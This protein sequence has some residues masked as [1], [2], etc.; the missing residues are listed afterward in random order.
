MILLDT[1]I[2]IWLA[3]ESNQLTRHHRQIIAHHRK[4]GLGISVI[5]C[6]EVAKLVEYDRLKLACPIEE[7]MDIA[8]SLPDVQLIE[9]T[10]QIAIASTKLPGNFHRD[11]ADQIIVATAQV[12]GI[13]LMTMDEKILKYEHVRKI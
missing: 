9:L 12:Y 1:H 8:I 6:W 11:P 13:E 5:S 4:N 7:W 3:D 10:P 2:W